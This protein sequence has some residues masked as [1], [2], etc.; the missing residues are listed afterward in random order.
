M[1]RVALVG[2]TNAGKSTLMRGLTG[3]EVLIADKLFATLDTT[4]RALEP[5]SRPRILVSD[6]VGFIHKLPHDLV[7]SFKSTLDEALEAT[8]LLQVVDASDPAFERQLQVTNE[9]LADIGA[10]AVPRLVVMNKMD[11]VEDEAPIAHRWPDALRVSAKRP[12]DVAR[13][14][15]ALIDH[16]SAQ[17]EERE[18]LVPYS[19]GARRAVIFEMCQ[20]LEER[21]EEEGVYYRVRAPRSFGA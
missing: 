11:R 15:Q 5:P 14:R 13:L 4:V 12:E 2:Y 19:E 6:T 8:L 20:V 7:A 18:L 16:F 1:W 10:A 9:V 17:L 3:S 21:Y